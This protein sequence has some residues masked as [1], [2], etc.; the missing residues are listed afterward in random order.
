MKL[1]GTIHKIFDRFT[2]TD[3]FTKQDFVLLVEE[4]GFK[5][6]P[7]FQLVNDNT[8]QLA[9]VVEGDQVEV[10]FNIKGREVLKD[11]ETVYYT[12]LD[13]WRVNKL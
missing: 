5:E 4:N 11:G 10:N 12:N 9:Q 6:Y 13:A 2:Y 8:S 1:T 7:K 3:K